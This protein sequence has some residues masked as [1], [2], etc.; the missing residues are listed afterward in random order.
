MGSD[1]IIALGLFAVA[2][3]ISLIYSIRVML[4]G[5]AKF[6]RVDRQGG[7]ALLSKN[8][9]QGGYWFF[10]PLARALV[11][12]HVTPNQVSWG[13]FTFGAIAG[14]CFAA[15]H[16]GS[17]AVFAA[18]SAILDALD[19]IVA[20]VTD[21]SSDAGEVLDAA[22][23]RYVEF[24]TITGLVVYYREIPALMVLALAALLGSFMISYSTAKAEALQITPPKGAMRRPERALY[25]ILGAALSPVT[26]SWLERIREYPIAIGHPMVVA[27]GLIAV[28]ANSSA[29]ERFYY[30]AKEIRKREA[31]VA[32]ARRRIES[33]ELEDISEEFHA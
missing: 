26:I 3:V 33:T 27:L 1:L 21:V 29:G 4:R 16:F 8:V 13:S 19:G 5:R 2:G 28:M 31:E 32:A 10:Q 9:M 17:G 23:D 22:V 6:S 15:G 18:I 11:A 24:F 20:R 12:C 30:I 14:I 25:L 7:S